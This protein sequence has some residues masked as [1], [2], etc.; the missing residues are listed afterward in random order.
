MVGLAVAVGD[1]L[2]VTV[3]VALGVALGVIVAGGKVAVIVGD[4]IAAA[5]GIGVEGVGWANTPRP[6]NRTAAPTSSSQTEQP[7]DRGGFSA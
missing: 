4:G 2:A 7:P 1:G 5:V 3:G 6:I